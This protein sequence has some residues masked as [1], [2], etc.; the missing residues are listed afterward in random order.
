MGQACTRQRCCPL[1]KGGLTTHWIPKLVVEVGLLPT[2]APLPGSTF[3]KSHFLPPH[4]IDNING[5]G[6]GDR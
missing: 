5:S 6:T 3:T 1:G 4:C 2:I